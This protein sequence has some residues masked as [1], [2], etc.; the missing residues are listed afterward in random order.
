MKK[1]F[2]LILLAL[3]ALITPMAWAQTP[4]TAGSEDQLRTYLSNSSTEYTINLVNDITIQSA[5]GDIPVNYGKTLNMNG[6]TISVHPQVGFPT[7]LFIV[8]AGA[9]FTIN[10]SGTLSG[11]TNTSDGGL[12]SVNQNATLTLAGANLTLNINGSV[13]NGGAIYVAN[14]GNASL[15]GATLAATYASGVTV[16]NGGIIYNAGTL[17]MNIGTTTLSGG[18][19]TNGG[20]LYV[21]GGQFTSGGETTF[22][23]NTATNGGALYMNGGTATCDAAF[24]GN[25]A[26]NGG[27]LCV[28]GGSFSQTNGTGFTNNTAS[29]YG[30]AVYGLGGTAILNADISGCSSTADRGIY[31]AANGTVGVSGG[32]ITGSSTSSFSVVRNLGTFIMGGGDITG[33]SCANGGGI[34]NQG[35]LNL[36]GSA[37]IHHCTANQAGGGIYNEGTLN[38]EGG[39]IDTCSVSGSAS[40][41]HGGGIY[42][43]TDASITMNSGFITGCTAPNGGGI[44]N[45]DGGSITINGGYI[46]SNSCGEDGGAIVNRGTLTMTGGAITHN[47]AANDG[48]GIC[49]TSQDI[50]ITGGLISDNVANTGNNAQNPGK[51]GGIEARNGITM[52]GTPIVTGNSGS[53]LYLP[54]GKR[55]TVNGAFATGAAVGVTHADGIT[56]ITSD[57]NTHNSGT[58]PRAYFNPDDLAYMIIT[59]NGEAFISYYVET[60]IPDD[61]PLTY[62]DVWEDGNR[63]TKQCPTWTRLSSIADN[64]PELTSGWYVVDANLTFNTRITIAAEHTVNLIL[65]DNTLLNATKGIGVNIRAI[66]HIWAQSDGDN[67]GNLLADSKEVGGVV[68]GI[69]G[70]LGVVHFHGGSVMAR[71]SD[72]GGAGIRGNQNALGPGNYSVFIYGGNVFG[73]GGGYDGAGIGGGFKE[74]F[75][76]I[77][78]TGGN[79][80]AYGSMNGAGMGSGLSGLS[81]IPSSSYSQLP[82]S[83]HAEIRIKGGNVIAFGGNGAGIG[84]GKSTGK[85]QL[86]GCSSRVYIDGG[87]VQAYT[88]DGST[89]GHRSGGTLDGAVAIGNGFHGFELMDLLHIYEGAKVLA[90]TRNGSVDEVVLVSAFDGRDYDHYRHFKLIK[91]EPCDHPNVNLTYTDNQGDLT[92]NCP[93]CYTHLPYT[94]QTEGDWNTNTNWLGNFMPGEGSDV[95]VKAAATIPHDCTA[96]VDTI[97]MQEGGSILIKDGGQLIHSNEGVTAT[98]EKHIAGHDGDNNSGWY[99]IA[100]PMTSLEV[101]STNLTTTGYDLYAFDQAQELEWVNYKEDH[102]NNPTL[103]F[104]TL[105]NGKGYLYANNTTF[106]A[107]FTGTL[108]NPAS[109]E[110]SLDYSEANSSPSMRG[111]N[112]VGNPYPCNATIDKPCYTIQT[113]NGKQVI[114]AATDATIGPGEGVMVQADE[115]NPTVTFTKVIPDAQANPTNNG[116]LQIMLSQVPEPVEGPARHQD[117]VSTSSTTSTLD[118]AIVSFKEGEQ[119]GKFYFGKQNANL[120]LPQDGEE[121]AIVSVGTDVARNVST[122]PVNFKAKENGQYTISVTPEGIDFSYLHLIDN[123]TGTDVDLLHPNAVIAGE[124]PQSPTPSYTFTAK[125]TDYE[126][127]FK[128]VFAADEADGG[129]SEA[130]AYISDGNL[131]VSGTGTL[132]VIDMLGHQLLSR[133]IHS[134]FRIPHSSFPAGVYVLRLI[135]GNDV[136]TQKVVVR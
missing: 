101:S 64:N 56:T 124:D 95:A 70:G 128:L 33:N 30:G 44:Y 32:T 130:F 52:S 77:L 108:A 29:N 2:T 62:L 121:Y 112:L 58:L 67:I 103:N 66:L 129:P 73:L 90:S 6:H 17:A 14:G 93:F 104:T 125:T 85:N 79:V 46:S 42:N 68:P 50:T 21:A 71:G 105:E 115:S 43:H 74:V 48:G 23:N 36:D 127:R 63:G 69:G 91:I 102:T 27:A 97:Y 59:H 19:A 87:I 10:G 25:T 15:N 65:A 83:P 98:M 111:W 81:C 92:T 72:G 94:F 3:M 109:G 131:I 4:V 113:E 132:Q 47:S 49:S 122:M 134:A 51:G 7:R 96:H 11:H 12:I 26:T 135:D 118:N 75:G 133:D 34:Y 126:S 100:S 61:A 86:E 40:N 45:Y 28:A 37:R 39:S 119:L 20:A 41:P 18:H 57:Y 84:G 106:E 136:R 55:I 76:G 38:F 1:T 89:T 82:A 54:S 110:V 107:A 13:T 8:Q 80:C 117:G 60:Q 120:Y 53:N 35:T 22:S 88:S 16:A 5:Y 99:F 116:S 9:Q 31:V 114:K 24:S 78:V 123:M